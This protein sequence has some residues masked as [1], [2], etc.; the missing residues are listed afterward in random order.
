ME[1]LEALCRPYLVKQTRRRTPPQRGQMADWIWPLGLTWAF[2]NGHSGPPSFESLS[3][4][5][6][7]NVEAIAVELWPAK[8]Q[9]RHVFENHFFDAVMSFKRLR[10]TAQR[11][12]S[13]N[14]A[15]FGAILSAVCLDF[16][17]RPSACEVHQ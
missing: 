7:L 14:S 2:R 10:S 12:R 15:W 11:I 4:T 16:R 3:T 1:S 9:G 8:G 5:T 6:F 13:R 17:N